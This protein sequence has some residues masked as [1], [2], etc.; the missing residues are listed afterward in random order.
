MITSPLVI[1]NLVLNDTD[2]WYKFELAGVGDKT[3]SVSLTF[4]TANGDINLVLYNEQGRSPLR[5][6]QQLPGQS[7]SRDRLAR[8]GTARASTA[9]VVANVTGNMGL[10]TISSRSLLQMPP[11]TIRKSRTTI[12]ASQRGSPWWNELAESG[13]DHVSACDRQPVLNDSMTGYA[14]EL[15]GV[16]DKTD[17]ISLTF[18]TANGDINL[19]LYNEQGTQLGYA[20]N[21][22]YRGNR[23]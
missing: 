10:P 22:N 5:G 14:S 6:E 20:A 3:D 21:N 23:P 1:D 4:D 17:S 13:V 19:V 8:R 11:E 16:G 2:D 9:R 18:D 12:S 7:V 15:A